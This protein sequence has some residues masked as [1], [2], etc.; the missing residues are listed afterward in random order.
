M[1]IGSLIL[2]V[3]IIGL[4]AFVWFRVGAGWR[5]RVFNIIGTVGGLALTLL[6]TLLPALDGVSFAGIFDDAGARIAALLILIGNAILREVTSG[7][8]G[9]L[10]PK[11][12]P[13]PV[14]SP[15][16]PTS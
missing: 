9:V 15:S 3:F 2:P 6:Q 7:P 5:T 12:A 16:P 8:P 4:F 1:T 14:P 11:A 13:D 10:A